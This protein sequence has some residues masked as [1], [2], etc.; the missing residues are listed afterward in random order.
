M[1]HDICLSL[2]Y[3]TQCDILRV[4]SYCCT[5]HYFV[6]SKLVLKF[7]YR[8]RACKQEGHRRIEMETAVITVLSGERAIVMPEGEEGERGRVREIQDYRI[9]VP[10]LLWPLILIR[11][12]RRG[13]DLG[14]ECLGGNQ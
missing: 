3:F 11:Q 14:R 4:R 12:S 13:T 10:G 7:S 2:T 1:I 5:Q 8:G 6:L 9:W